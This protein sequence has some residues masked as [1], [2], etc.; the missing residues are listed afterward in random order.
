[1][2]IPIIQDVPI[3][4]L[5]AWLAKVISI[6]CNPPPESTNQGRVLGVNDD[7]PMWRL[8]DLKVEL[9]QSMGNEQVFLC[10]SHIAESFQDYC[11]IQNYNPLFTNGLFFLL[12]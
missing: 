3:V 9:E 7:A 6:A 8:D 4:C 1:M 10:L 12:V 2:C 11:C 5:N